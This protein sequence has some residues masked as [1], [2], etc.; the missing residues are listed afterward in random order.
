MRVIEKEFSI[1]LDKGNTLQAGSYAFQVDNAGKI[2]HDL[3]IEGDG[4]KEKTR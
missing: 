4:V 2:E 1:E 3:A